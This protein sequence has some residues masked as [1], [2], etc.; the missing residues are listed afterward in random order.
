MKSEQVR[1]PVAVPAPSK[2]PASVPL[3]AM[4]KIGKLIQPKVESVTLELKQFDLKAR[5]WLA[6]FDVKL[7][8]SK[9][10]FASGA[11]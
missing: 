3:S 7:S 2:I 4:L 11:F 6:P 9:E 5:E 8:L 1:P 10:K